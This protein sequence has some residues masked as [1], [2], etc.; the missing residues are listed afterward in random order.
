MQSGVYKANNTGPGSGIAIDNTNPPISNIDWNSLRIYNYLSTPILQTGAFSSQ[1]P[2]NFDVVECCEIFTPNV[3][4]DAKSPNNTLFTIQE[5][6]L[7]AFNK[8]IVT[9]IITQP[10]DIT[11]TSVTNPTVSIGNDVVAFNNVLPNTVISFLGIG[12][13][14]E[15][16]YYTPSLLN[17]E[18]WISKPIK[19]KL[20]LQAGAG[21]NTFQFYVRLKLICFN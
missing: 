15:V 2:S 21:Y 11:G 9:A 4:I 14:G 6:P 20:Q 16:V 1:I 5:A 19:L 8:F 12:G 10:F 18:S 17:G 3:L 13:N 7:R